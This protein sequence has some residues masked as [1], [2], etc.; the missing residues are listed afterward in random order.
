M[1]NGNDGRTVRI[2]LFKICYGEEIWETEQ[3]AINEVKAGS[4]LTKAIGNTEM[5]YKGG[6]DTAGPLYVLGIVWVFYICLFVYF[7]K[8][9][10][11]NEE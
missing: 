9:S 11:Y 1:G 4:A 8:T 2:L 3:K 6:L 5:K 7:F 10:I